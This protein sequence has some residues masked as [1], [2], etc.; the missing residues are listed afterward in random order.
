MGKDKKQ[1]KMWRAKPDE[2]QQA[3]EELCD[4]LRSD[5]VRSD[6]ISF[7]CSSHISVGVAVVTDGTR[8][9]YFDVGAPSGVM[10]AEAARLVADQLHTWAD[11]CDRRNGDG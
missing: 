7:D 1:K 8:V 9:V 6:T 11:Y 2:I 3:F 5:Q 10:K 4:E